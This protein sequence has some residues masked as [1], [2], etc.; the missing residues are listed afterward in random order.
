MPFS[1]HLTELSQKL[2]TYSVTKQT[3]QIQKNGIIQ[4]ILSDHHGVKLEFNSNTNS[5][6]LKNI[7]KLN[8]AHLKNEW[9]KVEK[10]GRN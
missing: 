2:T 10:K 1:Q 3:Q 4:C 7:W 5:R 8:N 6:N 9:V